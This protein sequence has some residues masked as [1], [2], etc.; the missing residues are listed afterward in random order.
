MDENKRFANWNNDS[1]VNWPFRDS[2]KKKKAEIFKVLIPFSYRYGL[3]K[4]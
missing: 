3:D 2:Q 1:H 4:L